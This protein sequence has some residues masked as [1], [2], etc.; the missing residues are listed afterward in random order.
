MN[1]SDNGIAQPIELADAD[2]DAVAA[3]ATQIAAR[4]S[5]GAEIRNLVQTI[6][7]DVGIGKPRLNAA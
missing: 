1:T 4:E 5:L 6:L 2:L 3:G 7:S